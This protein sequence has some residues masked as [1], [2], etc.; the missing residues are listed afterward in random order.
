MNLRRR[1]I[2]V[3]V[4]ALATAALS[5]I[6][7]AIVWKNLVMTV[8]VS[9]SPSMHWDRVGGKVVM[10]ATE[11]PRIGSV[12]IE[13]F[14]TGVE[15]FPDTNAE[16][17]RT[18]PMWVHLPARTDRGYSWYG[19]GYGWPLVALTTHEWQEYTELGSS[20]LEFFDRRTYFVMRRPVTLP[21]RVFWPGMLGNVAVF[22]ALWGAVLILPGAV[23][24]VSRKRRGQCLKCGY[25]V[26]GIGGGVCPECGTGVY[27]PRTQ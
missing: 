3:V 13:A 10:W 1:G 24:Y 25:D 18:L 15:D 6:V 21:T 14:G 20:P 9:P 17:R 27:E 11:S 19:E 5:A 4:L 8:G 16:R 26:R 12:H 23:R 22:A 2:L 7:P